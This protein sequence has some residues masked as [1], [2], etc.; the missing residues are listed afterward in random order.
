MGLN[1]ENQVDLL[2]DILTDH[3]LD[4]CGTVAEYEQLERVIKSLMANTELD[5]HLKNVLEDV[6]RYSQ[7]GISSKSI[8]S[9]IQEHQ[10]SLSQWVEEMDSYS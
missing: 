3:Q 2:K 9:H 4:C 10:S 1:Y 5:S 7:S 8:D 6:Y